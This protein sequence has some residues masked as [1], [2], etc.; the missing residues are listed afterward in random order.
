MSKKN[1]LWTTKRANC[2]REPY[3]HH[4]DTHTD[5][6]I[7]TQTEL[8]P[9]IAKQCVT[10]YSQLYNLPPTDP[11]KDKTSRK[12]KI[13]D[14]LKQY[15]PTPISDSLIQDLDNPLTNEEAD[16]AL[17]QMKTA[18]S[19][20]PD[21]LSVGYYKTYASTLTPFFIL[22]FN[23]LASPTWSLN[24]PHRSNPKTRK[25]RYWT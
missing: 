21:G 7:G 16:L 24:R 25:R 13:I 4:N 5:R 8:N 3:N 2:W 19:P 20:G 22:A 15:S 11:A 9:D 1:I 12:Q 23:S 10:Y 14:F 17:K 18:K 6:C